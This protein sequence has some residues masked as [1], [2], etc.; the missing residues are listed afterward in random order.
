MTKAE[1]LTALEGHGYTAKEDRTNAELELILEAYNSRATI[2]ALTSTIADMQSVI[3]NQAEAATE[4]ENSASVVYI[5]HKKAK[6]E[7]VTPLFRL[8]GST[9]VYNAESLKA[10][11][12]L[13]AT[14]LKINGQNIL[15][16]A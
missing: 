4:A 12:D 2:E 1:L 16:E 7:L 9:S 3:D 10:D 11:A 6:Y 5:T 13:V 14:I 8:P 15:K